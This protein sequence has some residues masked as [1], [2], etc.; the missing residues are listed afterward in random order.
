MFGL[1]FLRPELFL[2]LAVILPAAGF[3]WFTGF[4]LRQKSR[5]AYGEEGLLGRFSQ[6]AALAAEY[7]ALAA[8]LG[9]LFMIVLAS[10]GPTLPDAP[11]RVDEGSLQ[12]V[13]LADVSKSMAAEDYRSIMPPVNGVAP[14]MVPG[15]YGTRLDMAK[16]VIVNEIMPAIAGNELGLATYTG[17]GF[18]Q[19]DLTD[20]FTSL[21]WVIANW[22]N[23]GAAPGNGSDYGSGLQQA[24]NIFKQT[25]APNKQKVIVWFTDGGFT[26]DPAALSKV[27][28][29]VTQSGVK[30]IIVGIG[31]D[32]ANPIP[33]YS[34]NGQLT[35]Y[36]QKNGQVVT[37]AIDENN[38]H[39][40]ADRLNATY[41]RLHPGQ[42]L[43]IHWASALAGSHTQKHEADVFQYPLGI[44]LFLIFG[45]FVRGAFQRKSRR[46]V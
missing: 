10:T 39:A 38:L 40:L 13:V 43:N 6:P 11:Q 27:E 36:M 4:K 42:K 30:V 2:S 21:R 26:G 14:D 31:S 33:V 15:P 17:D 41:I 35:G 37:T 24:L 5:K 22:M 18:D 8:W 3:F 1:H 34:S 28:D 23:I 45:L 29:E 25:P 12:V 19:A 20:D 9:A 7:A 16:L 44:G 46:I 32:T